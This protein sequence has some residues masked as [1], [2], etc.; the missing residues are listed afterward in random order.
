M[1][2][3]DFR[4][5]LGIVTIA[6]SFIVFPIVLEGTDTILSNSNINNYTGL[7]AIVQIAPML[8]MIAMLFGGGLL[9][10]SGYK[11]TRA[12]RAAKKSNGRIR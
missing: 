12:R 11:A 4:I 9:V 1:K 2:N 3:I 8:V 7:K 5:L 6:V 10:F